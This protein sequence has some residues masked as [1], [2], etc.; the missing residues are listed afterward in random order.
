MR[1]SFAVVSLLASL[2]S[3]CVCYGEETTPVSGFAEQKKGASDKVLRH[4]V[5]FKFKDSATKDQVNEVVEAFRALPAKIDAIKGFETGTNNSREGFDNGFTHCFF[6]TFENEAGRAAYL[7]HAD[8]KAFGNVLRPHL[9]KVFVI[10]YWG[11]P[12]S[13]D[14]RELRHAVFFKFKDG[15]SD[16]DVKKVEKA[17]EALTGKIKAIKAFEWGRNN[18]PEKHDAGFTHCFLVTF[19]SEAGRDEYLKHPEHESFVQTA[20]PSIDKVRVLDFWSRGKR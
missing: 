15:A 19:E 11:K 1:E 17:F 4:A 18:S 2:L 9:E 6:L 10:D 16:A 5:F 20:L 7:P 8:H 13:T 12:R 3:M 14:E